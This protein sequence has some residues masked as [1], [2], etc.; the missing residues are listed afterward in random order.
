[1]KKIFIVSVLFLSVLG[2]SCKHE[3]IHERIA[4][5]SREFTERS[6]PKRMD[7]YTV[8]DSIVYVMEDKTMS[9][10]YSVSDK[11]DNDSIYTDVFLNV[12]HTDLLNNIRENIGLVELKQNYVRFKYIY[13]S[14][15]SKK[16][17]MSFCFEPE[18]YR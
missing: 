1:M 10:Y 4:R 14:S 5:Q 6:C 15:T 9:Y 13:Y 18:M 17:Y 11:L 8:L 16:E 12:F 7:T 2:S 3:G